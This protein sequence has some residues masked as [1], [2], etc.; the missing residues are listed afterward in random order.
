MPTSLARIGTEEPAARLAVLID[1]DNAQASVIEDVLT[2]VAYLGEATVKRM[3]GDF[4]SASLAP[5]KNV[6]HKH[7]IKPVQQ[8]AYATGKNATDSAL[9]I[10]AMDLFYTQNFDVFCLVT[11]DSDFTGL[12]TRL[13][14]GGK[15][16][17]GFGKRQTP[18]SFQNACDKFIP[19]DVRPETPAAQTKPS[20]PK[21]APAPKPTPGFPSRL[22]L[23]A[24]EQS[25]DNSGWAHLGEFG[26]RLKQLQPDFDCRNHNAKKL[27]ELIKARTDLFVTEDRPNPGGTM[28]TLYFRPK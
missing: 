3:Y 6:L 11:S 1:A 10:D 16:V 23:D 8:F 9:I 19:T 18:K 13:K 20:S 28:T 2:K 15:K 12:A 7:A 26:N 27:S 24:L 14:E 5:W 25:M 22:A 17:Y 21:N 4:T